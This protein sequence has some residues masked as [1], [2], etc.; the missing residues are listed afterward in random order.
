MSDFKG[1]TT[2]APAPT[3]RQ[4]KCGR[5]P[6]PGDVLPG[7]RTIT[8]LHHTWYAGEGEIPHTVVMAVKRGE[9]HEYAVWDIARG[10]DGVFRTITGSY[11]AWAVDAFTEYRRRID[12]LDATHARC[13]VEV[14]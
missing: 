1:A 5:T 14:Q 7:G 3:E 12:L 10:E 4:E 9:V 8:A 13:E 2:A 6:T 11:F